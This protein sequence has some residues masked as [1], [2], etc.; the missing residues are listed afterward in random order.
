MQQLTLYRTETTVN[1][2]SAV[3]ISTVAD[4]VETSKVRLVADE[5]MAL[6][7]DGGVTLFLCI[8]VALADVGNWA[9]YPAPVEPDD[10]LEAEYAEA[11]KI[12]MGV[13]E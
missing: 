13:S 10:D 4:G 6:S 2:K 12:L 1:G 5:G 7:N 3:R 11:G 8:D 9:E